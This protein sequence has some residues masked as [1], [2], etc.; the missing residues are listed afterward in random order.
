MHL[1]T[2]LNTE[3]GG[4]PAYATSDLVER[5]PSNPELF[6]VKGRKDD[7]IMLSTGE[8]VSFEAL[9]SSSSDLRSP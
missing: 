2:T 6:R 4:V 1:L 3:I 7:Q 9:I 8:K 5:H